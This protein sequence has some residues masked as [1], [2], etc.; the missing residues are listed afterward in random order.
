MYGRYE[1]AKSEQGWLE[2]IRVVGWH[3]MQPSIL[4]LSIGLVHFH[5]PCFLQ[6]FKGTTGLCLEL[7]PISCSNAIFLLGKASNMQIACHVP[8]ILHGLVCRWH[9]YWTSRGCV[10]AWVASLLV[11]ASIHQLLFMQTL[12]EMKPCTIAI[13][14]I[15]WFFHFS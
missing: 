7:A 15:P 8:H 1:E 12:S 13:S 3:M 5:L 6:K 9:W 2:F 10:S 4:I 11:C 14:S